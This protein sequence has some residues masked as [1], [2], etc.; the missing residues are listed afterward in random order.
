LP[1]LLVYSL[2]VYRAAHQAVT[3]DEADSFLNFAI[4]NFE[5]SFYPSSGNH[6]LNTLLAR[7]S[8]QTFGLSQFTF[9]IPALIGAAFYLVA[10]AFL[11]T[12][13]AAGN[14]T[15]QLL[16]FAILTLNPFVLD[17]L[18]ASRGYA[19]ALGLLAAAVAL[20]VKVIEDRPPIGR[21]AFDCA[22]FSTCC[23]LT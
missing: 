7:F 16:S 23:G 6:V 1:A 20:A 22:L 4:G 2:I 21:A 17:Y 8:T 12:R 14:R 3:L 15:L 18:I 9:R 5:L 10:S 13:I 11:A 19:L